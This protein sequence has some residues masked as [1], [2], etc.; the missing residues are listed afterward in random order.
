MVETILLD[1]IKK[2]LKDFPEYWE[3]EILVKNKVIDDLRNYKENLIGSLL[4]NQKISDH[5][6]VDILGN[7]I[8]KMEE[9]IMLLSYK[10]F[11]KDSYTKFSNKIGLEVGDKYLDYNSDV[12]LTF[13]YKDSILEGGM[14]N[15]EK[16]KDEIFYN[17]IIA[18]DEIDQLLSEKVL[19]N[20]KKFKGDKF[21]DT[22]K[23]EDNSIIM[24]GNNLIAISSLEKRYSKSI[25]AIYIDPPYNIKNQNDTFLYNNRFKRSTWLTFMKNR[26]EISKKLLTKNGV[27]MVAIDENEQAYLGVLLDELFPEYEKHLITIVHNPRGIQGTNFSYNNEFVYFVIPKGKKVINDRKLSEEEIEWSPLRN[28]GGESLR[29]DAKNCFYP[30]IIKDNK[31][32]GFGDVSLDNDHPKRNEVKKDGKIYIYPIDNSGVERKWRYARQTVEKIKDM[33]SVKKL[34]NGDYDIVLGKNFGQYKTVWTNKKYDSSVHGKQLLNKVVPDSEF[35]FPKSLYA[36]YDCLYAVVGDNKDAKILDFF[37]GSGTTAHAVKLLNEE[38]N[39]NRKFIIVEQMDYIE[40]TIVNRMKNLSTQ[41]NPC[42]FIYFELMDLNNTF[43]KKIQEKETSFELLDLMESIKNYA[44]LNY[45]VELDKLINEP[46]II[47]EDTKESLSFN[48]LDLA[49]QKEL[50]IDVMDINQLYVNYSEIDDANY[51][52]SKK[53]KKFNRSFYKEGDN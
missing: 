8:F 23:F 15:E 45:L 53:D 33:L 52:V 12:V 41:E 21:E 51:Q 5:Y 3:N 44:D 26:L 20:I 22:D 48:A 40:N 18:R 10:N 13:P 11:W 19:T 28:W 34:A 47:N 24:K 38:D 4:S 2:I 29:T 6:K 31:I 9:F 25:D 36:V 49:K 32:I 1:E 39:G 37:G 46:V 17:K 50:L 16:S 35:T 14:S 30:I 43:V 7:S 42:E 27:L